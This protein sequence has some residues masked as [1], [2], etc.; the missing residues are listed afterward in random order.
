MC[1]IAGYWAEQ[2][3]SF[4]I[5]DVLSQMAHRGPDGQHH[6]SENEFHLFHSRLSI[7]DPTEKADQPMHDNSGRYVLAFNGE[8]YNFVHL[9]KSL[10]YPFVTASDTEVLL[11]LLI[12]Y[13]HEALNLLDGMFA[14]AFYDRREKILLL[15]R[16]RMGKKPLYFA[17]SQSGFVFGSELRTILEIAP[18]LNHCSK[19]DISTWLFWQTIPREGS[20]LNRVNQVRPGSCLEIKNGS[21]KSYKVY[22]AVEQHIQPDYLSL[23][24]FTKTSPNIY[25]RLRQLTTEAVVKRLISDVPFAAFLSGGVDSSIV[26]AIASQELGGNLPTFTMAFKEERFSEH[27][28]AKKVADKF[29]TNHHE[30]VVSAQDLIEALPEALKSCD[31]PSGDG[32]NTYLISK[33]TRAAGYKMALSGLGGDEWFL[34]YNY[35]FDFLKWKQRSKWSGLIPSAGLLPFKYRKAAELMKGIR[36]LDAGAFPLQRILWDSYTLTE[37]FGLPHPA[38]GLEPEL[39]LKSH[40]HSQASVN[41]WRYYAQPVLLRDADQYAMACGLEIRV[42]FMDHSLIEFALQLPNWEKEGVRPKSLLIN[43]FKDLLPVEVYDRPKQ[44]FTLPWELWMR[45]ELADFSTQ[46]INAFANRIDSKYLKSK[47]SDFLKGNNEIGWS[48]WWSI[49][50]LEHWISGNNLKIVE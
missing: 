48:R 21:L 36:Q 16:D 35:F 3:V 31:H 37:K 26:C 49:V 17:E 22:W 15:A 42:P 34:G 23:A 27:H 44:G 5:E 8:I 28:I 9:K 1:G 33:H 39:A 13:G 24:G 30:I 20:L 45:S 43:T 46:H 25:H 19:A 14:L 4:K 40:S 18:E 2:K 50:T 32:L 41:E 10:D 11:A 12:K 38:I 7:I 6:W 47:W 29:K